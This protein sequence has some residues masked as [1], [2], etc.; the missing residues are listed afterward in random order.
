M[1][2]SGMTFASMGITP[3]SNI[4]VSLPNDTITFV[5]AD[6]PA[7]AT[8]PLMLG[9]IGLLAGVAR[10]RSKRVAPAAN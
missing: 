1:T 4:V 3:R 10:R 5:V 9:G 8:L 6:V 7:P 2:F